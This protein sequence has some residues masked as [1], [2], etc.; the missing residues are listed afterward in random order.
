MNK[1]IVEIDG[2]QHRLVED[3]VDTTCDKCSLRGRCVATRAV[4]IALGNYYCRFEK[5][6]EG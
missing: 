1:I 4:C 5:E 3:K 2:Q 6:E